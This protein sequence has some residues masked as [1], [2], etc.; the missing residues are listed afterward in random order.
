MTASHR[1]S[2]HNPPLKTTP[3]SVAAQTQIF[4]LRDKI[5]QSLKL[6]QAGPA[7]ELL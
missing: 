5:T 1:T 6:I 2:P 7:G 4:V 3:Q